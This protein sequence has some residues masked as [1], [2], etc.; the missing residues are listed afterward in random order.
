MLVLKIEGKI[1]ELEFLLAENTK[2]KS[3]LK[4]IIRNRTS[5][6]MLN[7]RLQLLSLSRNYN[8][9]TLGRQ[10]SISSSHKFVDYAED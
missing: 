9:M 2:L 5:D 8:V 7:H 1:K 3:K 10:C 6:C 4:R